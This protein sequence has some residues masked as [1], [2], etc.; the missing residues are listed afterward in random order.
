MLWTAA[1]LVVA[2]VAFGVWLRATGGDPLPI[3]RWWHDLAGVQRGSPAFGLARALA[4]AGSGIGAACCTAVAVL[5][6]LGFRRIRDAGA[7]ATAMLLGILASES[8]KALVARPRPW[9]ALLDPPGFSYP[10]GHS[11]G[12][13]ALAVS[14]ALIAAAA[15]ASPSTPVRPTRRRVAW[16]IAAAWILLMMWSRTAVQV[17]WLSD[18]IAGAALGIAAALVA[19]ALWLRLPAPPP[20][21]VSQ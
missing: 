3:D 7:V 13:A 20:P 2:V 8:L 16:A 14:L 10:S 21:G 9:D 11:M 19:R 1:A 18:T 15:P 12:A 17:H 4:I 6:L 5:A